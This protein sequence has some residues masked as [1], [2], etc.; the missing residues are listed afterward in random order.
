MSDEDEF[1]WLSYAELAEIRGIDRESAI[2]L[3]RKHRWQKQ[4]GNDGTIRA[5]VPRAFLDPKKPL[6]EEPRED[7]LE[8]LR[9]ESG[10]KISALEARIEVLTEVVAH[11]RGR[12]DTLDAELKTTR[13][14]ITDLKLAEAVARTR[15][16][17]A[18]AEAARLRKQAE[19]RFWA[20]FRSRLRRGTG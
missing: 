4:P 14:Q 20:R 8:E 16:E 10:R 2:R 17:G 1:R 11:E 6:R 13:E 19:M 18:E 5:A 15:A 3:A 7:A 9:E 12:A